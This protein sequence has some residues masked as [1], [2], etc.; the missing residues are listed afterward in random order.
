MYLTILFLFTVLFI[1][2]TCVFILLLA[3]LNILKLF[4]YYYFPSFVAQMKTV[5]AG[6]KKFW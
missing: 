6:D 1:D 3:N 2:E 5:A 4:F